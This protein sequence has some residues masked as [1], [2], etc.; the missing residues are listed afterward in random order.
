VVDEQRQLGLRLLMY[1]PDAPDSPQHLLRGHPGN[2]LRRVWWLRCWGL[3]S[4]IL[5]R[6]PG[7][8]TGLTLPPWHVLQRVR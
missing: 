4:L 3:T 8:R 6:P 7:F 5:L 2:V 1:D